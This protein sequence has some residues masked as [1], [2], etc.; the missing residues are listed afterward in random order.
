MR[1]ITFLIIVMIT[2]TWQFNAQCLNAELYPTTDVTI[3]NDGFV[4]EV[5]TC[6]YSGEYSNLLGFTV[7]EDYEIAITLN[8]D[9]SHGYVTV[10]DAADGTTVLANGV[11]PLNWTATVSNVEVHWNNDNTCGEDTDCHTT[12]YTN[13][14]NAPE[15]APNDECSGAIALICDETV[16][17]STLGATDSGGNSNA[18]DDLWYSYTGSGNIEDI[19]VSLCNSDYDTA[20]RVYTDCSLTAGAQV[21]FNDDSDT[22]EMNSVQSYG[23]FTSDGATT[24]YIL[25]EGYGAAIGDFELTL[26]C[27]ESVPAP[28]NDL[29]SNAIELVLNTPTSGTTA[30]ATDNSTGNIDDTTCDSFSF[31]SDVWYYFTATDTDVS[32]VTTIT[33]SSDQANVAVYDVNIT[34]P[35]DYACTQL[36]NDSIACEEGNGGESF[37]LTGL[38]EDN[39]Y[40]IRVWSDGVAP[41]TSSEARTEGTFTIQVN[42]ATLSTNEFESA[43]AF[44]YYPNPVKNEMTVKSQSNIQNISVFNMLGQE[45]LRTTPNTLETVINMNQLQTGAY[46]VKVSINDLIE[47][48]RIIKQ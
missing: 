16:T 10:I 32:I 35:A 27:S 38:V 8:N 29:C 43:D 33:G 26:T 14:T 48:I 39:V 37:N 36:D 46:F 34:N 19:T 11:S 5:A 3:N 4:H 1:K 45:V 47:T 7:G 24:Y 28:P 41:R 21:L 40:F 25:V 9:G 13:L 42:D 44:A 22:C 18:A 6:N 2:F 20:I 23:T 31:K 15:P 30:G 12:S 17:G